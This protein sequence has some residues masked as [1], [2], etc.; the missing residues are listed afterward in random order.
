MVVQP[1]SVV[2]DLLVYGVARSLDTVQERQE[3]L[4]TF[5][6][7]AQLLNFDMAKWWQPTAAN[8]LD[9]V[10]KERTMAVVTEAVCKEGLCR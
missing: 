10:A 4:P 7:L 2:L 9:H 5:V 8:Y 6:E 3:A 1:Q